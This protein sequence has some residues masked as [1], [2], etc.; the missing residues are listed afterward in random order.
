MKD[1]RHEKERKVKTETVTLPREDR[2]MDVREVAAV[3]GVSE[4]TVRRWAREKKIRGFKVL[5]RRVRFKKSDVNA[6]LADH[7][8]PTI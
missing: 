3:F 4:E 8:L 6:I 5:S 1:K 7:E 2:W